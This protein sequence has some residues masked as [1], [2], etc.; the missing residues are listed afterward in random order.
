MKGHC[1]VSMAKKGLPVQA[2]IEKKLLSSIKPQEGPFEVNDTTLPGFGLRVLP[3]SKRNPEGMISF[4]VRY[5]HKGRQTRITI[6]RFPV[7]TAAQ[8]RAEA[9]T[10]LASVALGEDPQQARGPAVEHTLASYLEKEYGPWVKAHRKTGKATLA[11]LEACFLPTFGKK[12]LEEITAHHV[13]KW[14]TARLKAGKSPATVNRDLTALKAALSMAV[15]WGH[16]PEHPLKK[17]KPSKVEDDGKVRYLS[18]EEERRLRTAL[19]EREERIRQERDN[20]NDWRKQRGYDLLPDLRK[21]AFADHLKPLVLLALN[22]GLRRG[23]L[24]GL[25]WE[26]VD[27]EGAMLTVTGSSAKNGKPRHIPLNDEALATMK[28]WRD[29]TEEGAEL[30]FPGEKGE[31]M[32]DVRTSWGNLLEAAEI[33]NFRWHDMRHDFASK[34]VMGGVPLNTVRELLGHAD[35]K[36]TL[37]YAHLAPKHKAAA[38]AVLNRKGA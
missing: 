19:D 34:L 33:E 20:A 3:P 37:R 15:D 10:I 23:E 5:R 25:T 2:K 9:K 11:R 14:R 8:A 38:V 28:G 13:E 12:P 31:P 7:F 16:L 24:F 32:H 1:L 36:M 26:K 27:I 6:G 35:M 18:P 21:V 4:T 29:Q 17:V 22:T 30:C